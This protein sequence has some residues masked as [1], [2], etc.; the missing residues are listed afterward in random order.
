MESKQ[1]RVCL[2]KKIR[3]QIEKDAELLRKGDVTEVQWHFFPGKSGFG[4]TPA[5]EAELNRHGIKVIRH[6]DFL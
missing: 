2:E 4:P 1:G 3:R 6:E 5:L